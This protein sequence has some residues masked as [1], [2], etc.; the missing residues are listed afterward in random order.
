MSP[1]KFYGVCRLLVSF[2]GDVV[3]PSKFHGLCR[4]QVSFLSACRLLRFM[5]CIAFKFSWHVV[6]PGLHG[7][8]RRY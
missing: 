1:S 2:L 8:C 6:C 4:L 3:S 7:V 5:A